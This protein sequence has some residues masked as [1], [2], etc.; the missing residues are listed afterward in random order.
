MSLGTP[1][2]NGMVEW[3]FSKHYHR[4]CGM[5]AHARLHENLN[6]VPWPECVA[7]TNKLEYRKI[8][9]YAK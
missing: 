3:G 2:K 5:F 7:T 8:I 4:M 1:Q 6:T 9:D